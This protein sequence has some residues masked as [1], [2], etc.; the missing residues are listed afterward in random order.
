VSHKAYTFYPGCSLIA[1]AKAY[2]KSTRQVFEKLDLPLT[3]LDD[4]NC[5][6]TAAYMGMP[7]KRAIALSS[8]NLALAGQLDRDL[9]TACPACYKILLTAK[10]YL[11]E[12]K[13]LRDEVVEALSHAGVEY[14]NNVA[15]RHILD[16]L[17]NDVGEERIKPLVQQP[18]TG[19][20]VACYYGCQ[21]T[22]P[23]E[24]LFDDA[25]DPTSM[26]MLL[27]WCGATCVRFQLKTRCC[28]AMLMSTE[29]PVALEMTYFIL[30]TARRAGVDC[31]ATAC[32]LCEM[33]LDAYQDRLPFNGPTI[34]MPTV[35]FTQLMAY[36]LGV[37]LKE[38]DLDK[39]LGPTDTLVAKLKG[40]KGG[41]VHV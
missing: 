33:N 36:A 20:K 35:Y 18:L 40:L 31:V 10:H 17:V 11:M 12:N 1:N 21:I 4:W 15:V 24:N 22:R 7:L 26:D 27:T 29:E 19:L 5:C 37:P 9:A 8:R 3:D 39:N 41:L 28:G 16:I 23:Y 2:D 30:E 25:D 38:L 34:Q 32:P 14:K 6:G 13:A